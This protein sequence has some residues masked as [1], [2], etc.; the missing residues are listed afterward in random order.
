MNT[1]NEQLKQLGIEPP[2]FGRGFVLGSNR[3]KCPECSAQRKK[4]EEA[5]LSVTLEEDGAIFLC[6]HCNYSGKVGA[7]IS[8][9]KT[10]FTK[11]DYVAADKLESTVSLFFNGR[12]ITDEV[13][14]RNKIGY[15]QTFMPDE[16][17]VGAFT[18]PYFRDGEVINVKYRSNN[19]GFKMER[20][21]ELCLYGLDDISGDTLI[22]VEGEIDKLSAEVAGIPSCV[23]VPNGAPAPNAKNVDNH[24]NYLANTSFEGI[25]RFVIATDADAPGRALK[26]ELVRRLGPE[27]C[28]SVEWPEGV[29]DANELLIKHGPEKLNE[30][31][32]NPVPVPVAGLIDVESVA[33]E[34][35][36]L[37][38]NGY[39]PGEN[40]GT[41][42]LGRFYTIKQGQ[43]TVVTGVPSHGKSAW[44][45]WVMYSLAKQAGW[46][47]A[48]CS[49]ENQPISE[50]IIKLVELSSGQP[51]HRGSQDRISREMVAVHC[52]WVNDMF[53]FISLDDN[54]KDWSVL[55][56][57][58]LAKTLVLRKGIRG[59]VLDPWN[60]FDH[61]RTHGLSETEHIS[62]CLSEIKVFARNYGV[63]V[64]VV[65]HPHKI[66]KS[67]DGTYPIPNLYQINGSANWYNKADFGVAIWRD[68]YPNSMKIVDP[69]VKVDIQK[70]RFKRYGNVGTHLMVY[71]PNTNRYDDCNEGAA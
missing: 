30:F 55:G 28:W 62:R 54:V 67:D 14:R 53:T 63:H 48:I 22:F 20:G 44:V 4:S 57:L 58:Q 38:D 7:I 52:K 31:L 3:T 43:L 46:S 21:A 25:K 13:L 66:H 15:V 36:D 5:C 70:C 56:V 18:F 16:G 41:V 1:V 68:P 2:K 69:T 10:T 12:G 51:F 19:K 39:E 24:L 45:D 11:P 47:F 40:P 49:P 37:Y 9:R 59:L 65:A 60:E 71:D 61:T 8:T 29:K 42:G 27:R 6:H 50:H 33:D 32:T 64:W 34:V 23:S 26:A 35:L 17:E